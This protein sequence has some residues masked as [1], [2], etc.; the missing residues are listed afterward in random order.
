MAG[1]TANVR[2]SSSKSNSTRRST[3]L[4]V[5]PNDAGHNEHWKEKKDGDYQKDKS[6]HLKQSRNSSRRSGRKNRVHPAMLNTDDNGSSGRMKQRNGY[7]PNLT[8]DTSA[9]NYNERR[10]PSS[11]NSS[12]PTGMRGSKDLRSP[13]MPKSPTAEPVPIPDFITQTDANGNATTPRSATAISN[14]RAAKVNPAS[15]A[16]KSDD[17]DSH[18]SSGSSKMEETC[19]TL[20]DSLRLMC[21][22]LPSAKMEHSHST[23]KKLTSK[24]TQESDDNAE[25]KNSSQISRPKLL[26]SI[27]PSDTGK[28][29][30]V[31]D[32]DET[33]VHSSFRAVEG[34][35]FV[36]PVKIEDVVHFV[37]VAKRPGVDDFLLEMSKHYEIVIYTASLNKYADPLLDLLDIHK[38]I[39]YRLFRESC[40]FYEGNYVKDLSVL[41]RDIA[42]T[43]IIDNSPNSYLFHPENAID[44]SSFI[45]DPRDRE[46]DQIGSFL[47]GIKDAKDVRGLAPQWRNWPVVNPIEEEDGKTN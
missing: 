41:D 1:A 25:T 27:H 45:D 12:T 42:S 29:C 39:R 32:L 20:V 17:N 7:K 38:V 31:L 28:K 4:I 43:I 10:S 46:L 47:A 5:S 26:G 18:S 16:T 3:H 2:R 30:L 44:C 22:C 11:A 13:G 34:A 35:D 37:Y 40:V 23:S 15:P 33:L 6:S 19:D 24:D 36:I 21:C 14:A 8:V 9:S